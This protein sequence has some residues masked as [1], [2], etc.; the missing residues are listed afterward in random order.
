MNTVLD[1]S[2]VLCLMNSDKIRMTNFMT[3]MMETDSLEQ[4]SPATVSRMGMIYLNNEDI[5]IDSI[6]NK[7]KRDKNVEH[8]S[9]LSD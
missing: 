6:I 5:N 1:D 4:A 8:G 9:K 2:K 3:M 7:W